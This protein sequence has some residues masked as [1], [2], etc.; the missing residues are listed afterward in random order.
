MRCVIVTGVS[1]GLG[2]ALARVLV[3]RGATVLGVGRSAA[4]GLEGERYRHA[5][6][7][8]ADV[9]AIDAATG[10]ALGAIAALAPEAV[11]LVNNAATTEPM[12]L[13]ATHDSTAV[14]RAI[15]V[16][17]AAPAAL[18]ALF[19]RTF[20]DA[21]VE[22]RIVNVSSGAARTAIAGV[23]LYCEAKAGLEMLTRVIAGEVSDAKFAAVSLRPGV[24]DTD[25]QTSV[26]MRTE[27]EV[28][29]V[30]MFRGFHADRRL[31][32]P[33]VAAAK[34]ADKIVLA[35]KLRN[36]ATYAWP[37]LDKPVAE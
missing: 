33:D 14:A 10:P 4:P 12:G 11:C 34:I 37:D 25:M 24:I 6:C 22:R 2:A 3:D 7:D 31:T 19:L 13:T 30:A 29:A 16:N 5:T 18:C 8:F 21:G 32:A 15:A 17:L 20:A 35:R 36:G 27:V 23:G 1:R 9:A 28:P 26:R